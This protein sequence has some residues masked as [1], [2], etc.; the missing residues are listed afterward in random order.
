MIVTTQLDQS[1]IFKV[2][3]ADRHEL[4]LIG[5]AEGQ[6]VG[7]DRAFHHLLDPAAFVRGSRVDRFLLVEPAGT[8]LGGWQRTLELDWLGGALDDIRARLLWEAGES[9]TPASP[10]PIAEEAGKK[11]SS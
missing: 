3:Q 7:R 10:A 4:Q 2:A 11:L 6:M 5:L 8:W 9:V 1:L